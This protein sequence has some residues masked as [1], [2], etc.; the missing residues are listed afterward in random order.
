MNRDYFDFVPTLTV[1]LRDFVFSQY[2]YC[3]LDHYTVSDKITVTADNSHPWRACSDGRVGRL[4]EY[5]W[6]QRFRSN[7]QY[8]PG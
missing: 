7:L 5:A 6:G 8:R 2:C 1:S 3:H 4:Q